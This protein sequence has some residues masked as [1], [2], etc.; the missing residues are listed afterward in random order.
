RIEADVATRF[1]KVH[2]D[3]MAELVARYPGRFLGAAALPMQDVDA[4][5]RELERAVRELGLVAAYTGTRYPFP[6]DD[7]RL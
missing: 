2:N 6:L 3:A 7:P 1:C 4:A 5:M